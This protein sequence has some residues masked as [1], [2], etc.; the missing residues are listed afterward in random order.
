M[1]A[2]IDDNNGNDN[3]KDK[4]KDKDKDKGDTRGGMASIPDS[5]SEVRAYCIERKNSVDPDVWFDF[6]ASKGWMVG[7]NKMKDWKAAVRTWEQDT[8]P[9]PLQERVRRFEL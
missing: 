4:D 8:E 9:P 6:Y 1:T 5:V 3:N 7:K 2:I